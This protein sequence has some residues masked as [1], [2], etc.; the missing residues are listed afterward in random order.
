MR[1]ERSDLSIGLNDLLMQKK[2]R[3]VYFLFRNSISA[4]GVVVTYSNPFSIS[5]VASLVLAV[6]LHIHSSE[7]VRNSVDSMCMYIIVLFMSRCPKT[8]LTCIMSL[9][10]WYSIVAFQCLKVWKDIFCSLGFAN[11][12][13]ALLRSW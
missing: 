9:V 10:L 1:R 12:L 3:G 4:S 6:A 11:F 2:R 5:C 8:V 13:M 7:V